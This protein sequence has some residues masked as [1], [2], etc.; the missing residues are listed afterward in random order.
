MFREVLRF[1]LH[2]RFRRPATYVY[3]AICFLVSFIAATTDVIQLGGG[4]GKVLKNAPYILNNFITIFSAVLMVIG[5]AIMSVPVYRDLEHQ[6]HT[7]YYTY[8]LPKSAYLAGRFLGSFIV[9]LFIFLGLHLGFGLGSLM[10]WLAKSDLGPFSLRAYLQPTLL[11]LLPN[12]LFLAIVFFSMVALSRNMLAAYLGNVILLVTYLIALGLLEDLDNRK[13][14]AL[15]DPF[16]IV[17]SEFVTRYWTITEKNSFLIPFDPVILM[18]RLIWLSFSTVLLIIT[19]IRFDFKLLTN[20]DIR[21]IGK[22]TADP[23]AKLSP[24]EFTHVPV[25]EVRRRFTFLATLWKMLDLSWLEFKNAVK[26]IYFIAI[27]GA[28]IIF[29]MTDAWFVDEFYNT[30]TYPLTF[31]ILEIRN[32]NFSLFVVALTVFYAGELVWRERT[33]LFADFADTFPVPNWLAYGSKLIALYCICFLLPLVIM[34][35]GM[36]VQTVKGFYHYEIPLY[37]KQLFLITLPGYLML[38]TLSFFV[39]VLVNNK[40]TGHILIVLLVIVNEIVLPKLGYTHNLYL[41]GSTPTYIYSAMNGFGHFKPGLFWFTIYWLLFSAILVVAGNALWKRGLDLK[42]SL[43][44][45]AKG[46]LLLFMACFSLVGGYIFLHTNVLH[47]Y[48]SLDKMETMRADYEKKYKRYEQIRQPRITNVKIEADLFPED[49]RAVIR[50]SFLLKN[51]TAATIDSLHISIGTEALVKSKIRLQRLSLDNKTGRLLLDDTRSGYFIYKLPK[52]LL[53]GGTLNLDFEMELANEGFRVGGENNSLV[54]NGTFLSNFILPSIGYD[55]AT[56]LAEEKSRKK[57]GLPANPGMADVNDLQARMN[58]FISRDANW[59]TFEATLST[60]PDQIAIA[61]GYLQ[62]EWIENGRRFFQ[63][64]MD[65]EILNFYSVLSARYE[66]KKDQ[67]QPATPSDKPVAIEIYYHKGHEF[68]L[69]RMIKSVK[70]SLNYYSQHFSPYQHRQIRIIEFPRYAMFAQSFPNTIPYSESIG[71][72]AQIDSTHEESIDYP[73]YVTAHEVAHQWWGHQ[74]IGGNVQGA[75]VL[76]ETLS[77]YAALMVMEKEYGQDKVKRFLKHEL[78]SYLQGRSRETDKEQPLYKAENQGYIYYN[79][80]SLAMYALRDYIGEKNVNEALAAFLRK[81]AYQDPPYTTS[82]ELLSYIQSATPDSL[83]YLVKDL[84]KHIILY[85]NRLLEA[86][87]QQVGN[88]QYRVTLQIEGKK[89]MADSLGYEKEQPMQDW[90]EVGVYAEGK[91]K[92]S[93]Q[94]IYLQ[95][96]RLH[97]GR[98][99]LQ[100]M[101]TGKPRQAGVDPNYKL[102]DRNPEDNISTVRAEKSPAK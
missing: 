70:A 83:Q 21:R 56:E 4:T 26:D 94:A 46:F 53:P 82:V 45:T 16:G 15:L 98:N 8:S 28:G 87:Y 5:S 74:L 39:Q 6:V 89:L 95:K 32:F 80:G 57:Y 23:D 71:F 3:F 50:G 90:I 17:A 31:I 73:F 88:N 96:H 51:K 92:N 41:F 72:I 55:P 86:R 91:G 66:V 76:S 78:D 69:D 19:F 101:V 84:F 77:Q 93:P 24:H 48:I 52:P 29:L 35:V 99:T 43:A 11:F 27:L 40:F 102:I 10:P 47:T 44:G 33:M 42:H 81:N 1:E 64:K 20:N 58:P 25:P 22:T 13:L 61:P 49:R 18:N 9:L 37:L 38:A 14:A 67:W 65:S 30:P 63:Y 62:K 36:L 7:F 54:Q 79:K 68:N 60:D 85:E 34:T 75:N 2:Y 12:L 59:I 97:A 100:F